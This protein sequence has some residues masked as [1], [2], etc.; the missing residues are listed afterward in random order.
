MSRGSSST[1]TASIVPGESTQSTGPVQR[2]LDDVREHAA[3]EVAMRAIAHRKTVD[4]VRIG[5][6]I[7][8]AKA[9]EFDFLKLVAHKMRQQL[10]LDE[11]FL[12]ALATSGPPIRPNKTNTLMICGSPGEAVQRAMSLASGKLIGRVTMSENGG[13]IW[14]ASVKRISP[15]GLTAPSSDEVALWDVLSKTARAPMDPAL[16]PPGSHSAA[17]RLALARAKLARL[18]PLDALNE[19][20]AP[21]GSQGVEAPTYLVDIRS[22]EERA[23]NGIIQSALIIDRNLLEWALDPQSPERLLIATQY[24]HRY[25]IIDE[26]GRA[27][28]LAAAALQDIGLLNATDIV[29]GYRAWI[30]AGLPADIDEEFEDDLRSEPSYI[31]IIG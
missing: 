11:Q 15:S 4:G 20:R 29:G 17:T 26:L 28:S 22:Y 9:N 24:D 14:L 13:D 3:L 31:R 27:S 30:E 19:L 21:S 12:F 18:S 1:S 8:M 16:P 5:V 6:S 25:I 10:L 2:T 23:R 7:L